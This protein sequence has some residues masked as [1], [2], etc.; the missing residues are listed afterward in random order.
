MLFIVMTPLFI[1][2]IL[3]SSRN[4]QLFVQVF[5]LKK[6]RVA[7]SMHRSTYLKPDC[8]ILP[9]GKLT[10]DEYANIRHRFFIE[11]KL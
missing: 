4:Q 10:A 11:Q 6:D 5:Y 8:G 7:K 1:A 3:L 2:K 9:Q